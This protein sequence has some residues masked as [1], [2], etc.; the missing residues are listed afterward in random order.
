M[1]DAFVHILMCVCHFNL[2]LLNKNHIV[3][4][5]VEKFPGLVKLLV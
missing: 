1:T 3:P 4:T 5:P 2:V